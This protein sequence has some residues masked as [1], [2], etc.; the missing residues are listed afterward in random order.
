MG[1][2]SA[3]G[4]CCE[5][6][7]RKQGRKGQFLPQ[8]TYRL[9]SPGA[10]REQPK[11]TA[12]V[13]S[14]ERELSVE[15][16][17]QVLWRRSTGVWIEI[18]LPFLSPPFPPSL[19]VV[20]RIIITYPHLGPLNVHILIPRTC[21]YITL[22]GKRNLADVIKVNPKCNHEGPCKREAGGSELETDLKIQHAGFEDRG[23]GHQPSHA[24]SL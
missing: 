13:Q 11:G 8:G 19:P 23:R 9:A 3:R 4:R 14:W 21:E 15:K 18:L 10:T 12:G 16:S 5:W 1:P 6:L 7:Q 20:D 22:Y 17:G 24:S 2:C